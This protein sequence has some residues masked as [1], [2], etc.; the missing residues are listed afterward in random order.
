VL[1]AI[2]LVTPVLVALMHMPRGRLV[3]L[4][5]FVVNAGFSALRYTRYPGY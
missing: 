5:F 4:G 1:P 3:A 2:V